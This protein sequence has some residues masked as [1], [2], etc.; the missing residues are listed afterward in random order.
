[1][2][3]RLTLVLLL[4]QFAH[5]QPAKPGHWVATWGTAQLLVR[6]LPPATPPATPP[7]KQAPAAQGFTNQTV[8]MVV[9]TSIGGQRLRIKVENAFNSAPVTIGA[10][11][12]ALRAKDSE[13]VAASDRALTF[14]GKPGCILS[15]GVV[16][17][18]DPVDLKVA[19]L[20]DLAVSLYFP[21]ETGPP[22][23]H[24]TGLHTTYISREGDF[25]GQPAI[26]DAATTLSYYYLAAVDVEAPAGAAA[27]VTFGDSITDGTASTPNSDHNWPSLLAAR[28]AKNK[29]T[30]SVGVANMGIGGN[31]VLY[32]GSGASA[33]ARLD[34]DVLSQ[35]GVKWVMLLEGINDI[36]RVGTNTPE[37]P[38]A[39]GLI[40]AYKQLIE[41]AHTHGIAVIGCTLTPYEGAG[42]S[43]E[44]G[45]A[46]RQAVNTF[47]RTGGAFDAVVDFEAA[48]RDSGNPKRF[49]AAFDPGDHLHPNDAGYQAMADA[50][51]LAIFTRK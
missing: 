41:I 33:L 35:S 6:P 1:M 9:R 15:P 34:R 4:A 38:T 32:D 31:R 28:L 43:R 47:I 39:D 42:Y 19:P 25:T 10:A 37:A 51:D 46:V 48:T 50:V 23:S 49:R 21:G 24:G 45:E 16:R 18:S 27:L 3:S 2:K 12:I 11:H 30:A 20:T 44:P 14:N 29:K 5:A 36:G 13:I 22:T 17:L 8:R 7:A 40:A 26:A